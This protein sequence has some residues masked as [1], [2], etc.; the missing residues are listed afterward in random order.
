MAHIP[1]YTVLQDGSHHSEHEGLQDVIALAEVLM[2][3][4]SKIYA[5]VQARHALS[6]A[7]ALRLSPKR[8]AWTLR[9]LLC[10][11]HCA[12]YRASLRGNTHS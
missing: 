1:Q 7:P 2:L 3:N 11:P 9:I 5:L 4:G 10:R 6:S 12:K 8:S